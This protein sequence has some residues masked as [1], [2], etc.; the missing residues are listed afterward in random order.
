MQSQLIIL[1]SESISHQYDVWHPSRNKRKKFEKL[2]KNKAFQELQPC[3]KAI[4][5]HFWWSCSNC[6]ES[7]ERL[8]DMWTSLLYHIHNIHEW[9]DSISVYKSCAHASLTAREIVAKN[10]SPVHHQPTQYCPRHT[11]DKRPS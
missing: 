11:I 5:N 3:V 1:E 7:V 4:I 9:S 2:C 8:Q 6:G 10:G